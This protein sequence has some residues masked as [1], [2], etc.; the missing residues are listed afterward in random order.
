MGIAPNDVDAGLFWRWTIATLAGWVLG[1]IVAIGLSYAIIAVTG[2]EESNLIVGLCMGAVLGL[3]QMLAVRST[4]PLG[5]RWVWG[6]AVGMGIAFIAATLLAMTMPALADASD[7]WLVLVAVI[8]AA[9]SGALQ[10]PALREHTPKA[11]MW[12]LAS[13]VSWAVAWGI[14]AVLPELGLLLGG[15]LLGLVGGGLLLWILRSSP[16]G[17]QRDRSSG[18]FTPGSQGR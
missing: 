3:V 16:A 13:I 14:T 11:G 17:V 4:L 18:D 9:I 2:G 6:G 15:A 8:G 1:L 12:V 7:A 10:A 5:W